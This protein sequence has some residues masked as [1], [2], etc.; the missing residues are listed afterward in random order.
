MKNGS[1]TIGKFFAEQ[2]TLTNHAEMA[3]LK[4]YPPS[5]SLCGS[6][7]NTLNLAPLSAVVNFLQANGKEGDAFCI[8][9]NL[10]T[11][12]GAAKVVGGGLGTSSPHS[13]T[14]DS[15]TSDKPGSPA[16]YFY[17]GL[18]PN[19]MPSKLKE[20]FSAC[21]QWWQKPRIQQQWH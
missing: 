1:S 19:E 9:A 16:E 4:N 18:T 7:T 12:L 17:Y 21:Q 5:S 8:G 3:M 2:L 20:N 6:R 15:G 14:L 11:A 13:P 10:T